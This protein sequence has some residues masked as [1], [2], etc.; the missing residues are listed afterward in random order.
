LLE[1]DKAGKKVIVSE[2]MA[3]P[4][5][6]AFSGQAAGASKCRGIWWWSTR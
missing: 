2:K 1:P 3:T 4:N 5:L 6:L